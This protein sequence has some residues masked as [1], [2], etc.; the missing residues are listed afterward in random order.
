MLGRKIDG[1]VL[2]HLSIWTTFEA[3]HVWTYCQPIE[4]W[5]L[6]VSL[7]TCSCHAQDLAAYTLLGEYVGVVR[8]GAAVEAEAAACPL[9]LGGLL[10][11]KLKTFSH[12]EPDVLRAIG[13]L[14]TKCK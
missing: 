9:G 7:D 1:C 14:K 4:G 13:K 10:Q 12:S 2:Q 5:E 3:L 8:T 6:Q 11:D